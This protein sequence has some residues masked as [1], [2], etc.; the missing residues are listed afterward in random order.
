MSEFSRLIFADLN[1][2]EITLKVFLL[3]VVVDK[4]EFTV[5]QLSDQ[6]NQL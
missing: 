1:Q 3:T 6:L 5:R 4:E 2:E